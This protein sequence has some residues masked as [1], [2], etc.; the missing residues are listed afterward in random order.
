MAQGDN[1]NRRK[2]KRRPVAYDAPTASGFEFDDEGEN[3][4]AESVDTGH[5]ID[6]RAQKIFVA[7]VILVVVFLIGLVIPK[8][9]FNF[10]SWQSG[11]GY[12]NSFSTIV[13]QFGDNISDLLAAFTGNDYTASSYMS[14]VIRYIVIAMAG[15]GLAL[16]GAVYQGSFRNALVSPST[17][18]VMSGATLGMMLWVVFLVDDDGNNVSWLTSSTGGSDASSAAADP[19]GYLWS[20]YSIAIISF[21]GCI[22]VVGIV[23]FVMRAAGGGG[24]NPI[25]LIITGQIIGAVMGAISNTI[26]YYYVYTDPYGTKA[27][28]ITNLQIAS[29]YRTFTVV[30]IIALGIPLA[31]TFY[32]VMKLRRRMNLLAFSEGEARTMGVDTK[33]MQV[34]VVALCTLL[35]A[36][37]VSFCGSVGFVGFLVPHLARRLVGPNF[38]YLLPASTVIGGV[39]VLGAYIILEVTL[40]PSYETMVGMYISI[41]GAAVFLVTALRGKGGARGTFE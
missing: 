9:V 6:P 15:A 34:A 5:R 39:F 2:D 33:R 31:L 18:G 16:C 4:Y 23:L 41:A 11:M 17:L 10:E 30:D 35:T 32:I 14:Q 22:L 37:I 40:G 12:F 3:I 21:I 25:M 38:S 1:R 36:I 26:R 8:D 27:E 20:S 24:M 19:L 29:F 13:G 28:L 7:A